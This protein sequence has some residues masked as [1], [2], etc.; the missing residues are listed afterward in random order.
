MALFNEENTIEQMVLDT[1]SS[2]VSEGIVAEEFSNYAG[3][4]K[5][6]RFMPAESLGRQ[7]SDVFVDGARC[8]DPSEPGYPDSA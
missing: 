3:K 2:G 7:Y 6:W 1:L 8:S 5:G 4:L